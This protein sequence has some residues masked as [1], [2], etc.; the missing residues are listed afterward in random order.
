VRR[1]NCSSGAGNF[2]LDGVPLDATSKNAVDFMR[3]SGMPHVP[4][5]CPPSGWVALLLPQAEWAT[6]AQADNDT[7]EMRRWSLGERYET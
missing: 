3:L 5:G 4:S 2:A 7:Q 6:M 1:G